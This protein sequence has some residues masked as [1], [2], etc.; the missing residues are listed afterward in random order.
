MTYG[1]GTIY[2]GNWNYGRQEGKG[3][4]QDRSGRK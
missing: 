2:E 1:D 4:L 3:S